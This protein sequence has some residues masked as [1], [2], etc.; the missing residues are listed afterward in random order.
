VVIAQT[1][2]FDRWCQDCQARCEGHCHVV[3]VSPRLECQPERVWKTVQASTK[4]PRRENDVATLIARLLALHLK[5]QGVGVVLEIRHRRRNGIKTR[6]TPLPV[7]TMAMAGRAKADEE[8]RKEC[9][10]YVRRR[11]FRRLS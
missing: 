9:L 10:R 6:P 3:L 11:H 8:L 4:R 1:V 5:S 7:L 2:R